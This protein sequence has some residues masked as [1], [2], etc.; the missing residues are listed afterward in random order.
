MHKKYAKLI[1]FVYY[2]SLKGFLIYPFVLKE[3]KSKR[4]LQI[5][6]EV[7]LNA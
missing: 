7:L 5:Q 6:L 3:I 2:K 1:K 4:N